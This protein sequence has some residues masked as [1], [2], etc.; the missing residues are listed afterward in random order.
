MQRWSLPSS[1]LVFQRL[2]ARCYEKCTKSKSCPRNHLHRT[3]RL[4][5]QRSRFAVHSQLDHAHDLADK[6]D[7]R[8]IVAGVDNHTL[9]QPAQDLERLVADL[10]ISQRL[11]QAL[12]PAA[13]D[14]GQIAVQPDGRRGIGLELLLQGRP[15]GL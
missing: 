11:L 5:R 12:D 1:H 10:G 2:Q 15:A 14:L 6:L 13:V 9:D 8:T 4:H 3:G 7:L